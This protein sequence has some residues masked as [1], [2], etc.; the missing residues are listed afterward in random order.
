MIFL[1]S[2]LSSSIDFLIGVVRV[3]MCRLNKKEIYIF[4]VTPFF[5]LYVFIYF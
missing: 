3:S 5:V 4:Y 2:N 1:F